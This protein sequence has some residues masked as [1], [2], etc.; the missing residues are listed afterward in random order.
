MAV[1]AEILLLP[2]TISETRVW[3]ISKS[4]DNLY[5]EIPR[6]IKNSSNKISPGVIFLNLSIF[7][8]LMIIYD[9]RFKSISVLP[10][11]DNSPLTVYSDAVEFF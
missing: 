11:E 6:G 4:L 7:L 3:G 2:L 9:L 10:F 5:C 1:S 8:N